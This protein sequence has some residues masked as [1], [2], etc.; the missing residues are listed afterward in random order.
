VEDSGEDPDW[1][2]SWAILQEPGF[3]KLMARQLRWRLEYAGPLAVMTE[4]RALVGALSAMA[5]SP[6]V[7]GAFERWWPALETH[8]AGSLRILTNRRAPALERWRVSQDDEYSFLAD[9][10]QTEEA[11]WA[12]FESRCRRNIR[13]AEKSGVTVRDGRPETDFETAWALIRATSEDGKAFELPAR[14]FV[15][16]AL[17]LPAG[18][19]YVAELGGRMIGCTIG[20]AHGH[21]EAWLGGFDRSLRPL[22]SALL[23]WEI[24][25]RVRAEGLR[26][27]DFGPQS[28]AANP[29]LTLFKRSFSPLLRPFY[30]YEIRRGWRGRLVALRERLQR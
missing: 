7:H 24:M 15:R 9:L 25:R 29:S 12:G 2:G 23:Y 10:S 22:P 4:R 26:Y 1:G 6:E 3:A 19:L 17:T 5:G 11:L 20:L 28:I 27:F 18:R 30:V 14:E 13:A 21:F 16:E 8:A